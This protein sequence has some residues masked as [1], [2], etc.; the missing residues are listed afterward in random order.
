MTPNGVSM[1]FTEH[2][3]SLSHAITY[4]A[5]LLLVVIAGSLLIFRRRDVL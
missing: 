2:S 1:E 4:W 3:L 5:V